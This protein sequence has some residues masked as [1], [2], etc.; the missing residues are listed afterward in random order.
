MPQL[1]YSSRGADVFILY[2]PNKTRRICSGSSSYNIGPLFGCEVSLKTFLAVVMIF[3]NL[4][5]GM[6]IAILKN[7]NLIPLVSESAVQ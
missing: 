1:H 5:W 6:L 4:L 3:S 2:Y 7:V